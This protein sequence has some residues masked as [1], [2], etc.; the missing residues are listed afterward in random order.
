MKLSLECSAK[1]KVKIDRQLKVA[2]GLK[3]YLLVPDDK[4]LLSSIKII[5]KVAEPQKYFAKIEPGE[6][7]V[8]AKIEIGGDRDDYLELVREFQELES[9]LSFTTNGSLKS[10][11]WDAPKEDFIPETEEEKKQV[12]VY[13]F[14]LTK[15]YPDYPRYLDERE[16]D[17]I[18]RSKNNYS[19]LIVP[20]AFY[21]EGINEFTSRRYITAFYNFYFILE[22]FYGE[23]KTKNKDVADAFR[24]SQDFR[25]I[26]EW[27][28]KENLDKYEKHR[29]GITRFCDEEKVKYDVDGLIDLLQKV[30][31]NLHHYSSKSSKHLGTPFSH[32]DFESIAF[33]S[34]GLALRAILQ[35]IVNINQSM[36]MDS[37]K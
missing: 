21:R 29:I 25:E 8:K 10:I 36:G 11:A 33:L 13:G 4:G 30:R 7:K 16:F 32:E 19:S 28:I 3:E 31:G 6:G 5:K 27:M 35:K 12:S 15:E 26:L 22:D 1:G 24:N 20:K 9:V 17:V 2:N 23:K 14:H 34:M 37:R 18:I